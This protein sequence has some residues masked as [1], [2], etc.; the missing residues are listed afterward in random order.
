[1]ALGTMTLVSSAAA[2]GPIYVNEVTLVGDSSYPTGGSTGLKAKLQALTLDGREPFAVTVQE[3]GGAYVLNY[4]HAL[5]KLKI[6]NSGDGLEV[7]NATSLSGV[8]H[9]LCIWSK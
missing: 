5:E 7:T 8:T 6:R 9:K 2:N 3:A 1:M 4:D